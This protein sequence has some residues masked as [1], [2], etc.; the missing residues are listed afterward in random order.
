VT[1]Q[2]RGELDPVPNKRVSAAA[3]VERALTEKVHEISIAGFDISVALAD[4]TSARFSVEGAALAGYITVT[5]TVSTQVEIEP[6]A[7]AMITAATR[8]SDAIRSAKPSVG[9]VG[10]PPDFVSFAVREND[11]VWSSYN[12]WP[13]ARTWYVYDIIKADQ[14]ELALQ[15]DLSL[16]DRLLAQATYWAF[17]AAGDD[18]SSAVLLAAIACESHAKRVFH[19]ALQARGELLLGELLLTNALASRA[20]ELYGPIAA[21][22]LGRSLKVDHPSTYQQLRSLFELRNQVAHTGSMA[23]KVPPNDARAV[24]FTA[25]RA[26]RHAAAWLTSVISPVE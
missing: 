25:V 5:T 10:Q 6:A 20:F 9:L 23:A 11:G 7:T 16:T 22:V 8:L 17:H 12:H 13:P 21:A 19:H 2:L 15:H 14:V 1:F 26:A 18:P 4:A 24:A 3:P